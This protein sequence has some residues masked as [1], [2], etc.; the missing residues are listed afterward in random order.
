MSA[1]PLIAVLTHELTY[2]DTVALAAGAG[3]RNPPR[4][5]MRLTYTQALQEA[6]A[7]ALVVPAR[8][9]RY[10]ILGLL[11][12]VDGLLVS[13]G[14]DVDPSLYGQQPHP[15]LGGQIDCRAD[16]YESEFLRSALGQNIPVLAICHGLQILNVALSGTL[17]QHLP[18]RTA[19]NHCQQ[20]PPY[21]TSHTVSVDAGSLLGELTGRQELDVNSFHHQA[22]DDLSVALRACA[23]A[24]DGTVEAV[25]APSR[26]FCLGV[27]W[28]AE[29]LTHL[30]EQK[31]I[32][33]AFVHAA[34]DF[35]AGG[36]DHRAVRSLQS[37]A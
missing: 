34:G 30:P 24:P 36:R 29:T 18:D 12:R 26:R 10:D 5:S 22:V 1:S 33:D 27:Q 28:H 9:S 37:V 35:A 7:I 23:W 6:G 20:A 21:A 3:E 17:V 19:L 11:D 4:L 8:S 2:D 15:M 14:P 13:G 32:V 16:R 25:W 31:A